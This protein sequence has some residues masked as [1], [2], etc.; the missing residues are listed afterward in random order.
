MASNPKSAARTPEWAKIYDGTESSDASSEDAST[1]T[2]TDRAGFVA[3]VSSVAVADGTDESDSTD[4]PANHRHPKPQR[5]VDVMSFPGLKPERQIQWEQL[6][7][8]T[9]SPPIGTGSQ[10]DIFVGSLECTRIRLSALSFAFILG[11][12]GFPRFFWT[13]APMFSASSLWACCGAT[14]LPATRAQTLLRLMAI[15]CVSSGWD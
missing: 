15:L 14:L 9:D 8:L 1:S 3:S 13:L 5:H 11:A 10:A 12:R 4:A 2:S 6:T 7:I